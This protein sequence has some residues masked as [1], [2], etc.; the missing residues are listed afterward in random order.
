MM[1]ILRV[2]GMVMLCLAI[3]SCFHD[4]DGTNKVSLSGTIT[5]GSRNSTDSD[6]NDP[7][8]PY[9]SNNS[10]AQA[11]VLLNPV[12]L[13]GFVARPNSV[14]VGRFAYSDQGDV[15]D[16]YWVTLLEGQTVTLIIGDPLGEN[17]QYGIGSQINN[18]TLE[19]LDGNGS[20]LGTASGS[21]G[22]KTIQVTATGQYY[23]H[24]QAD[25]GA[26]DY[27]LSA[28][29]FACQASVTATADNSDLDINQEF[30]PGEI[31]VK[32]KDSASRPSVGINTY[33]QAASVG[34]LSKAGAPG[35]SMLMSLGDSAQRQQAL[36]ALNIRNVQKFSDNQ[37]QLKLET[38]EVVKALRARDDVEYAK[39]NYIRHATLVPNDTHYNLQW[40]LP[41][42]NLP[43]AWDINT[44]SS[45]VIVAVID[46]GILAGHP[47]INEDRLVAGYDFIR[48]LE[49]AADGDGIDSNPNDPSEYHGTHVTGIIAAQTNNSNGIAGVA[50]NIRIMPLRALGALG[51]TDY[52]IE[53]A[54]LYAAG[55]PNDAETEAQ[56][57]ARVMAGEVAD[58]INL[59]LGGPTGSTVAPPAYQ[60]AREQGVIIVAAAGND[61]SDGFSYPAS[62][63]GVVSVSAV[64]SN[65]VITDYSNIGATIDVAA[66]G[67]SPSLGIYSTWAEENILGNLV[68]T[69]G[70]AAG[71]SMAA[72]HVAGVVALMK[73]QNP[74]LTPE[75]FDALLVNGKLTEDLGAAGR[76]DDYGY[77]LIDASLAVQAATLTIEE[78]DPMLQ[79]VPVGLYF[80][81]GVDELAFNLINAGGGSLTVSDLGSLPV[82]LSIAP[83]NVDPVTG[84]GAYTAQI[85]RGLLPQ[86]QQPS[87]GWIVNINY[88]ATNAQNVDTTGTLDLPVMVYAQ[89]FVA[90]ASYH[91]VLLIDMDLL[92]QDAPYFYREIGV[93]I[94]N[95][96]YQYRFDQV[97]DGRYVIVAGSDLNGNEYI[98]DL[99]DAKGDY[100]YLGR[101]VEILV[102][103]NHIQ[104]LDFVSGYNLYYN[105]R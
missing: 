85:D 53:Q 14:N 67:G 9:A 13:G 34:L 28:G 72:P 63:E 23:L 43:D 90:N 29:C 69:Y 37:A 94:S 95:G 25:T 54:I 93:P 101:P 44:G 42:I 2:A 61:G 59:S 87:I 1:N 51:G 18:I 57:A 21:N 103:N 17:F 62:L 83:S 84:L 10:L 99:P 40:N 100:P 31:I 30:V 91:Y 36:T 75:F 77:G 96:Q 88:N 65:K 49:N 86:P 78:L 22:E 79:A 55:L 15:D 66:P 26:S 41:L 8:A 74:D 45:D 39:P 64:D 97:P 81:N 56:T 82:W 71:T 68:Y 46:S 4:S 3:A 7:N 104:G 47:D 11:Q 27:L 60:Q 6:I 89:S 48:D 20:Y 32:F 73:S 35:R 105:S 16:Y 38:L 102:G 50:W 58:V 33:S 19:L 98:R 70:Y 24:V 76:D 80:E 92:E 52:D 5:A 12:T